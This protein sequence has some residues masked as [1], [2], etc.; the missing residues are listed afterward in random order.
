MPLRTPA[1]FSSLSAP[2]GC[3]GHRFS[4]VDWFILLGGCPVDCR[5]IT[6]HRIIGFKELLLQ[7]IQRT[8][9]A[10][11]STAN[12]MGVY[13]RCGDICMTEQILYSADI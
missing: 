12:D 13:H 8:P 11:T 6:L 5:L 4:I 10:I 2:A 1:L 9:G 7:Q 3:E